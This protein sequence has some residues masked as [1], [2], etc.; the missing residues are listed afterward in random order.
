MGIFRALFSGVK[1]TSKYAL[2]LTALYTFFG[3]FYVQEIKYR[4]GD[5]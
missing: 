2:S 4:L 3:Y 5:S 1:R